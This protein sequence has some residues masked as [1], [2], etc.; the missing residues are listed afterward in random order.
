MTDTTSTEPDVQ[1]TLKQALKAILLAHKFSD[2]RLDYSQQIEV[3]K[4]LDGGR[5]LALFA[6]LTGNSISCELGV[7]DATTADTF[8]P[9]LLKLQ[10]EVLAALAP[11]EDV[12]VKNLNRLN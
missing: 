6:A 8:Q 4:H 5:T 2:K 3:K 11:A 9:H 10:G 12:Q 1:E 7:V